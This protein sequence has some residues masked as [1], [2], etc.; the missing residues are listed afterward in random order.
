MVI[1][2]FMESLP[3]YRAWIYTINGLLIFFQLVFIVLA[4]TTL[5]QVRFNLFP[6]DIMDISVIATYAGIGVQF[7]TSACGII[8]VICSNRDLIRIYWVFMI[9][10]IAFDFI[11]AIIWAFKFNFIHRDFTSYINNVVDDELRQNRNLTG[12]CSV[13]RD[14]HDDLLC[15][16]KTSIRNACRGVW[17][18]CRTS[19]KQDCIVPLLQWLHNEIDP[20]AG[21]LEDMMELLTE[22]IYRGDPSLYKKHWMSCDS[23]DEESMINSSSQ[24][25]SGHS[26][27]QHDKGSEKSL[28][29]IKTLTKE[30]RIIMNPQARDIKRPKIIKDTSSSSTS[31]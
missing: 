19:D 15:C 23:D 14:V 24:G 10:L 29:Q 30:P 20:L 2:R 3:W 31:E 1:K 28:L 22:I 5:N 12:F 13:F 25:S 17:E 8:G 11:S 16:P 9:P 7:F 26:S 27:R 18:H 6:L 21:I 4:Y